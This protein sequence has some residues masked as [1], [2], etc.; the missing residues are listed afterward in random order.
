MVPSTPS[1]SNSNPPV[2]L[3]PL[4][5]APSS[6]NYAGILTLAQ[7]QRSA[8]R[9]ALLRRSNSTGGTSG[10]GRGPGRPPLTAA[11]DL[12]LEE[13]LLAEDLVSL[14]SIISNIIN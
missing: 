5:G 7:R 10:S 2:Q 4:I 1:T 12:C 13:M 9:A 14:K 11:A 6:T 8:E 3:P